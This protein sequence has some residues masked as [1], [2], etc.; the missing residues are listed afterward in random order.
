[1]SEL[2]RWEEDNEKFLNIGIGENDE[3]SG[4]HTVEK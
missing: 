2:S 1:L 4:L 3:V